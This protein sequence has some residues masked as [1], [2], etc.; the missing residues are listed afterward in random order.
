MADTD[1]SEGNQEP[2]VKTILVVEDDADIA[3]FLVEL[4]KLEKHFQT[5]LVPNGSEALELVKTVVPDL[6][7]LDYQLPGIDGLSLADRLQAIEML[8]D[9]PILFM[10]AN[11]PV[12]ELE[13][14]QIISLEKPFE[15]NLFLQQVEQLLA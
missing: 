6:V 14:R 2:D 9:I 5:L 11:P 10:S 7:V 8:K 12:Q 1:L 15:A 3:E 4:L 13:K